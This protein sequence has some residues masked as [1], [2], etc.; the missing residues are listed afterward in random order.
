MLQGCVTLSTHPEHS[1]LLPRKASPTFPKHGL[2]QQSSG[3]QCEPWGKRAESEYKQR[4]R[5]T[6]GFHQVYFGV[7]TE[8]SEGEL[9]FLT[10]LRI[11]AVHDAS[12]YGFFHH[13]SSVLQRA[14]SY[15]VSITEALRPQRSLKYHRR[16]EY[17]KIP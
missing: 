11:T 2:C 15:K 13:L 14:W 12:E 9:S 16:L 7:F 17:I 4:R 5:K 6:W 3:K 8:F 10:R 1:F